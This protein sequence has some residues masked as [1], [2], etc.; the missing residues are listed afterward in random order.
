MSDTTTTQ[1]VER[2]DLRELPSWERHDRVL[3]SFDR[4]TPG[5]SA[6][7]EGEVE[8]ECASRDRFDPH[9]APLP[10]LHDRALAELL[11]DL[12]QGH[13]EGFRPVHL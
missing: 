2:V 11:V 7:S 4:L 6:D 9:V 1:P 10:Q 8:C 13:L 3:L 12:T 5:Q